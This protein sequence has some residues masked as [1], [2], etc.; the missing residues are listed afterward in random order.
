MSKKSLYHFQKY[1]NMKY[2]VI[3]VVVLFLIMY[4]QGLKKIPNNFTLIQVDLKNIHAD[5]IHE[6]QPILIYDK[7]VDPKEL[8]NTVFKYFFIFQIPLIGFSRCFASANRSFL[9]MHSR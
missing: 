5:I 6:K 3:I 1:V 4:V 9:V 8:M 2:L 7:I